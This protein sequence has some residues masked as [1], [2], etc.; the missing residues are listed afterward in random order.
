MIKCRTSDGLELDLEASLQYRVMPENIFDIYTAYGEQEKPILNRV[1]I[2]VI[3]DTS[4]Q[5]TSTQFFQER[6]T[7]QA[8]MQ[9]DLKEKV[10]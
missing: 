8:Q 9:A 2:D 6:S 4:T 5:Y 10:K 3:S 1:V 7:I